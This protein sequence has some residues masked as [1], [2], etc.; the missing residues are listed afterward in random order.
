[1][2]LVIAMFAR[3]N[4]SLIGRTA[5]EFTTTAQAARSCSRLNRSDSH[6]YQAMSLAAFEAMRRWH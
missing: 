3:S 2:I 4:D 5:H 6:Y 1:M